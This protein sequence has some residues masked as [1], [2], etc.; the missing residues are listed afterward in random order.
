MQTSAKVIM[1]STNFLSNFTKMYF[2]IMF[3]DNTNSING[4]FLNVRW[5]LCLDKNENNINGIL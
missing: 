4:I 2:K 5:I 3:R 1:P